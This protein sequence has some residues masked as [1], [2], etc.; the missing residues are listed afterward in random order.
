MTDVE[1]H[2]GISNPRVEKGQ[3]PN[4]KGQGPIGSFSSAKLFALS[5]KL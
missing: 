5:G 2:F 1:M 3:G 4:E